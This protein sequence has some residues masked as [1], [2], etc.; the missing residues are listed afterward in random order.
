MSSS[1][2]C[3]IAASSSQLTQMEDLSIGG[4]KEREGRMPDK[5][6]GIKTDDWEG[7]GEPCLR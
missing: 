1:A 2:G 4:G 6:E 7:E 3:M 5:V